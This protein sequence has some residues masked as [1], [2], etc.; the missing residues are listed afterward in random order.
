M[1]VLAAVGA[2][3]TAPTT[4]SDAAGP[5]APINQLLL[6]RPNPADY[7]HVHNLLQLTDRIYSGGEPE[8][9]AAFAE[10][11]KLGVK[12]VVSVDGTRPDVAAARKHGIRYVH[13]PIG[14]DSIAAEAGLSLARVVRETSNTGER[15]YFHCHHGKHRGPAAA[16]VA[17]VAAEA[18]EGTAALEVLG[19][20]GTSKDYAGLW[21]DVAA[22]QPPPEGAQLPELVEVA[23]VDSIVVAMSRI[24]HA[25]DNV[26]FCQAADWRAPHDHPDLMP[27][28]EALIVKE[29]LH[30]IGRTMADGYDDQFVEWLR[31]SERLAA[32]LE[33][34]VRAGDADRAADRLQ[35][36]DQS[37]KRCH[38]AYRD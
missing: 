2:D 34:A 30:E 20:A 28:Q 7:P 15:V 35:A 6:S 36:L 27:A 5:A 29:G 4:S 16:A 1:A 23:E 22:F 14:Y 26:K 24:D 3:V 8:G 25:L 9:E 32:E 19:A 13:I 21:R 17:C 31:Q 37:C 38:S 18:V 10:L 11:S 33:Q 12:V